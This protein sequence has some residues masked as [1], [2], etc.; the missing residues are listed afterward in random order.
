MAPTRARHI[1]STPKVLIA[2]FWSPLGFPVIDALPTGEKFTALY[3]CDNIVPQ[4]GEQRSSDARQ[5]TGRKL[6][7]HMDNATP[8]RA[9]LTKSRLKPLR[10]REAYHPPYSPDL[11]PSDFYLSGKQKGQM[12]ASEFESPEHLLATI[13]RLTNAISREELESVFQEWERR[14]EKCI[15]IGGD[16]VS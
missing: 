7:V 4:I 15:R 10:L 1:I 5:K 6:V 12:T 2:I 13:R 9:K 16:Y 11:A 8:H 14:L 3:F